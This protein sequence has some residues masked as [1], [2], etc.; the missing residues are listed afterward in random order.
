MGHTAEREGLLVVRRRQAA[1]H[2]LQARGGIR[3][4]PPPRLLGCALQGHRDLGVGVLGGRG[5]VARALL[6]VIGE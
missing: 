5:K 2:A 1:G 3:R 6:Q 4:A